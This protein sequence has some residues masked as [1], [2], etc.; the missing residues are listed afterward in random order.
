MQ[1]ED[2]SPETTRLGEL[3]DV[4]KH[5]DAALA[6]MV[7][8]GDDEEVLVSLVKIAPGSNRLQLL[9]A[10]RAVPS[11]SALA[12]AV[13]TR[14]YSRTPARAHGELHALSKRLEARGHALEFRP[15][16]RLRVPAARISPRQPVPKPEPAFVEGDTVL[17]GRVILSGGMPKV[18][19][20]LVTDDGERVKCET[21]EK[22]ARQL[23]ARLYNVVGL[24]GVARWDSSD[25]RIVEFKVS[26]LVD[27]EDRPV[28]EAFAEM[29]ER[30]GHHF[31]LV[32][33][34]A[35]VE[36]LRG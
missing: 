35:F 13:A 23:G 8:D 12:K 31:D 22:V 6:A 17:Y 15:N 29:R 34:E 11:Y 1:G 30:F 26:R 4:L 16:R 33:V 24:E 36:E 27:F 19:V 25:W 21:D 32:D 2:L 20:E 28:N 14:D 9:V 7:G 3:A 18:R 5:L 10:E